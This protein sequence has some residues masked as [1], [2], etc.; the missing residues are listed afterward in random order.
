MGGARAP[1]ETR[2]AG[3]ALETV[4][5]PS[6]HGRAPRENGLS[7]A[8]R[9][10]MEH[11]PTITSATRGARAESLVLRLLPRY[12]ERRRACAA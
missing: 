12:S 6:H 9:P 2:S 5:G 7:P 1:R 11:G 10:Y 8:Q 3:L 4:A